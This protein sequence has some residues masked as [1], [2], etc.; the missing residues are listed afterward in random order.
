MNFTIRIYNYHFSLINCVAFAGSLFFI[1]A[2]FSRLYSTDNIGTFLNADCLYLPSMYK[3]LFLDG[4]DLKN[5]NLIPAPHFFPDTVLYFILMF[6]SKNSFIISS[7]VFAFIQ[8]ACILYILSRIFKAILPN[9]S[10]HWYSLIYLLLSFFLMEYQFLT[11][12]YYYSFYLLSNCFHTGGFIMALLCLLFTINY[13]K[14]P[15]HK[16]LLLI[17]IVC[18]GSIVSDRLFIVLYCVPVF[19][20]GFFLINRMAFKHLLRFALTIVIGTWAGL[21]LFQFL[22]EGIYF[23]IDNPHKLLAFEDIKSSFELFSEQ[24]LIYM[25]EFGFKFITIYLFILSFAAMVFLFFYTRKKADN[26]MHFYAIFN[27][28]FSIVV[29]SAPIINGNYTGFDTL[30]YNIYPLYLMALN[31]PL[32][33][34]YMIK[35]SR[36]LAIGRYVMA[37]V[38]VCFVTIGAFSVSAEDLKSYFSYYPAQVKAIDQIA[39]EQGLLCGVGNFW[40][41]KKIMLFSKKGV[42]VYS[43]FEDL[44]FYAHAAN[45]DWFLKNKFNFILLN[46]FN[47]TIAYKKNDLTFMPL[48]NQEELKL[49]KTNTFVYRKDKGYLPVNSSE[50]N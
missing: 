7:F 17:L 31:I 45:E 1:L 38:S 25:S 35:H 44:A 10:K 34:A 23:H 42:K 18:I 30:R 28:V 33:L 27:I 19:I 20:S 26:L 14:A 15:S 29:L 40:E 39:Q 47:D 43:V 50:L 36:A 2:F 13:Y 22:S 3:D 41:A 6:I 11:K 49:I 21:K 9:I 48:R 32:F 16:R 46:G 5:W 37:T 4:N 8:Y 24:M 12:E